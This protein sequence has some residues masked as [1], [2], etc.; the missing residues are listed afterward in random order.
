MVN[1]LKGNGCVAP[2][3]RL[4]CFVQIYN[5]EDYKA[6]LLKKDQEKQMKGFLNNYGTY[7]RQIPSNQ[8]NIN[9]QNNNNNTCQQYN[10]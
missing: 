8:C 10:Y 7:D 3:S 2:E 9:K 1:I 5:K 6:E 4:P